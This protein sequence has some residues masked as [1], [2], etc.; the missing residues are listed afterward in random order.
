MYFLANL[1]ADQGRVIL[2]KSTKNVCKAVVTKAQMKDGGL[3]QFTI[4]TGWG[5]RYKEESFN[6]TVHVNGKS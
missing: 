2:D 5:R 3:W 1:S 4:G 6:Y